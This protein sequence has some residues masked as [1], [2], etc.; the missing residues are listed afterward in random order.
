MTKHGISV[1]LF[2]GAAA[3][4][5]LLS[6]S[7]WSTGSKGQGL[8]VG[9]W[10]LSI[11]ALGHVMLGGRGVRG[12]AHVPGRH[13]PVYPRGMATRLELAADHDPRRDGGPSGR[14]PS[15]RRRPE[16]VGSPAGG[17]SGWFDIADKGEGR[18]RSSM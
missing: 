14:R 8:F 1:M 11:L 5:F 10:V 2:V 17:H 16:D 18:R 13:R 7:L 6:V 9:L 3:L 12:H 4:S 15:A